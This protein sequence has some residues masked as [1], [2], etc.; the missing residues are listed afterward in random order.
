MAHRAM[1][2]LNHMKISNFAKILIEALIS[3]FDD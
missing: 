2:I 3:V 1:P